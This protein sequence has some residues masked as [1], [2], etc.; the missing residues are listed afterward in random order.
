MV[1]LLLLVG[2]DGMLLKLEP[3]GGTLLESSEYEEYSLVFS[4]RFS[5]VGIT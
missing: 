4:E 3:D 2:D 5:P 1:L